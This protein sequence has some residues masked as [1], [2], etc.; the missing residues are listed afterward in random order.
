[1]VVGYKEAI[2]PER[3]AR[4]T[5]ALDG[6]AMREIAEGRALGCPVAVTFGN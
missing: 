1:M 2:R 3:L 6:V 5:R 4:S